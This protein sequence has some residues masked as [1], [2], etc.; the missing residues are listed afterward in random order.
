M[1][2]DIFGLAPRK[3]RIV[4]GADADLVVFDPRGRLTC[5]AAS[6]VTTSDYCLYEGWECEGRTELTILRGRIS[7]D[8]AAARPADGATGRFVPRRATGR[9]TTGGAALAS[10]GVR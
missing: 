1:P 8:A 7:H 6:H 9:R 2:A 3:G 10:A 5:T 4:P